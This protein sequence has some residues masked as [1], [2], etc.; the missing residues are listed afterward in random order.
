MNVMIALPGEKYSLPR[1]QFDKDLQTM[2]QKGQTI[3][4]GDVEEQRDPFPNAVL[5]VCG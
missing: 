5:G 1:A 3:F 4:S 2:R